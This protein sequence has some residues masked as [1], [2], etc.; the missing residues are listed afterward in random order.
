[1]EYYLSQDNLN[2]DTFL[3]NKM[4]EEVGRLPAAAGPLVLLGECPVPTCSILPA[5]ARLS[6]V[7]SGATPSPRIRGGIN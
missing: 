7:L 6:T 3:V 1:M 5:A 4:S 2:K